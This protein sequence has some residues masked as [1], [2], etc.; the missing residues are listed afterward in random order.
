MCRITCVRQLTQCL[1]C[2]HT[3]NTHT[4]NTQITHTNDHVSMTHRNEYVSSHLPCHPLLLCLCV[5]HGVAVLLALAS[6]VCAVALFMIAVFVMAVCLL[7]CS[8][9]SACLTCRLCAFHNVAVC[10]VAVDVCW[11]MGCRTDVDVYL[12][13]VDVYLCCVDVY[14]C[15]C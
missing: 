2:R 8:S 15:M 13:C 14:L 1:S 6:G 9:L 5:A 10:K 7:T 3:V 12:C 4:Q 11:C